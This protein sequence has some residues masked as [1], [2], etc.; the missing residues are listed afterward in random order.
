MHLTIGNERRPIAVAEAE[1]P[2]SARSL[3]T[4][5]RLP[6]MTDDGENAP[7]MPQTAVSMPESRKPPLHI[8]L[9]GGNP[10]IRDAMLIATSVAERLQAE[11]LR[12]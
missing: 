9:R 8:G 7:E 5:R 3:P 2:T 4:P 6:S 12:A 11:G 1:L 10:A